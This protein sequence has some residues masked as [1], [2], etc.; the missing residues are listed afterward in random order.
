MSFLHPVLLGLFAL[1]AVPVILHF[2]MRPEPKRLV[3]PALRLIESRRKTNVRRLRLRHLWL[4]LLRMTLIALLVFAI[5]RPLVP[6][7]NYGLSTVELVTLLVVAAD[8]SILAFSAASFNRCI[9][10]LS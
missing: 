10:I 3:F 2:L 6:A 4:L 5:A 9:A 7:A 8:S 1:A